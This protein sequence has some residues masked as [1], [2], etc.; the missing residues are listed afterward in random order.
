MHRAI[1]DLPVV[2]DAG[3]GRLVV[4]LL[5]V[6]AGHAGGTGTGEHSVAVAGRRRKLFGESGLYSRSSLRRVD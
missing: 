6:R 3:D 4:D 1:R 2:V 5:A